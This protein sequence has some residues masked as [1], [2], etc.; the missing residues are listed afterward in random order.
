MARAIGEAPGDIL[1]L[2]DNIQEI[3]AAREAGM[4]AIHIDRETGGGE[5]ASF[6]G[7]EL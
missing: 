3:D 4:Q 6:A 2:S 1:F 7:I 5:I